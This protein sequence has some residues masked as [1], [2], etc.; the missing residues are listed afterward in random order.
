MQSNIVPKNIYF[1]LPERNV[2]TCKKNPSMELPATTNQP[3]IRDP[4]VTVGQEVP[5][6]GWF[7]VADRG[8]LVR[9]T[10]KC[11]VGHLWLLQQ[12]SIRSV[13]LSVTCYYIIYREKKTIT[14]HSSTL[15]FIL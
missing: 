1:T 2:I 9:P 6:I 11:L 8:V 7:V 3:I 12:N 13:I 15:L 10:N 5:I 4:V 14:R